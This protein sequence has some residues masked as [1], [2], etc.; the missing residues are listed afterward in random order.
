MVILTLIPNSYII[1]KTMPFEYNAEVKMYKKFLILST[2]IIM[3]FSI[4]FVNEIIFTNK[5]IVNTDYNI[6]KEHKNELSMMLE[7][8]PGSGQYEITTA[9]EWPAEGYTF[10]S[11][12]SKC[13]N[14]GKLS[15]DVTNKKVV[16]NG[17]ASDKCYIYFDKGA[18]T[19]SFTIGGTIYNADPGMTWEEWLNSTYSNDFP[20][21]NYIAT[22]SKTDC[23]TNEYIN[24]EYVTT[25][26]MCKNVW[27]TNY[28]SKDTIL[29]GYIYLNSG[30]GVWSSIGDC[31]TDEASSRGIPIIANNTIESTISIYNEKN[32][33]SINNNDLDV[34]GCSIKL[35]E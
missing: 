15:W 21:K 16:F 9:S 35:N 32:K 2:T 17:T 13:E 31:A 33:L 22:Y 23:S 28:D 11:E 8:T 20:N 18:P 27:V 26:E 6:I 4:V 3:I 12:L 1:I 14:G 25:E 19:I 7:T 5:N 34:F 29:P 30:A 10:N 24:S